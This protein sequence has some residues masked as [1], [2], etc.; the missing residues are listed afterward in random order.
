MW[1][2]DPATG[3]PAHILYGA[4]VR[5][6]P[7]EQEPNFEA[8]VAAFTPDGKKLWTD[9]KGPLLLD[10]EAFDRKEGFRAEYSWYAEHAQMFLEAW[11]SPSQSVGA[12]GTLYWTSQYGKTRALE[13]TGRVRWESEGASGFATLDGNGNTFW[14]AS[15][16]GLRG[17]D[18]GVMWT[19]TQ[20]PPWR[21]PGRLTNLEGAPIRNLIPVQHGPSVSPGDE[22]VLHRL[23]GTIA[24]LLPEHFAPGVAT[25]QADGLL[26]VAPSDSKEL[27]SWNT[28]TLQRN[29]ATVLNGYVDV[30]PVISEGTRTVW[31]VTS[32]CRVSEIDEQGVVKRWHQMD[33]A[34]M[35]Q[36][37]KVLDGVLYVLSMT[38]NQLAPGEEVIPGQ[39][40]RAD[41]GVTSPADYGCYANVGAWC[42]LPVRP[43]PIFFLSAYRID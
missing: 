32:D 42:G 31:V 10:L 13:P 5:H 38:R 14:S 11:D 1:L 15:A 34:P 27:S 19:P 8:P 33:G 29:W 43:G 12:D 23:D 6:L 28:N 25:A 24:G 9:S 22:L 37:P 41:G 35:D 16:S 20:L 40:T 30:G 7:L 17:E 3:V 2:L 18:G 36:V 26:L 39:L 4:D 21:G